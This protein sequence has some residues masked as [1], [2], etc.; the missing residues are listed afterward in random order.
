MSD[1][2][3][4]R[5]E[6]RALDPRAVESVLLLHVAWEI[7]RFDDDTREA[8]E[9]RAAIVEHDAGLP[10]DLAERVAWCWCSEASP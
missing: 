6:L 9:E 1:G 4:W 5:A 7:E 8:F 10:R 2:G 3:G